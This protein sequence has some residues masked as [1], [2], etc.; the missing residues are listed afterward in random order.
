[1]SAST[2]QFS[3]GVR[4][5]LFF[6]HLNYLPKAG[7]DDVRPV[8]AIARLYGGEAFVALP[9]IVAPQALP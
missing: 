2:E 7:P 9:S 1:M 8:A 6:V 5:R 4:I 3:N